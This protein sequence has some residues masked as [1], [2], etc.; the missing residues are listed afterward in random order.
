MKNI[1]IYCDNNKCPICNSELIKNHSGFV[2]SCNNK[3][4]IMRQDYGGVDYFTTFKV[5]DEIIAII[6]S[7]SSKTEKLIRERRV[8]N[9]I[10]YWKKDYRYV[11]ELLER[12]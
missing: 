3:C 6:Y 9:K 4:Y 7:S 5:F 2:S 11:A 10:R 12:S 1:D 8:R